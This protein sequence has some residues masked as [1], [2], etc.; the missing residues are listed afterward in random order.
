MTDKKEKEILV[1][2]RVENLEKIKD[3]DSIYRKAEEYATERY[4]RALSFFKENPDIKLM[5]VNVGVKVTLEQEET[6][7]GIFRH[8]KRVSKLTLDFSDNGVTME[9]Y[10]DE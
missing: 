2:E 8:A 4:N 7:I 1:V 3:I 9:R 10:W 6:R 5:R